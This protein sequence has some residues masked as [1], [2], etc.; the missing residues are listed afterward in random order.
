MPALRDMTPGQ[1]L[2]DAS[3]AEFIKQL[4]LGIAEAQT[5]LD[6]NSVA[7]MEAFTRPEEGL[8]GRSLLELGLLPA[9]Y[10]YQHADISVSLQIRLEVTETDEFGFGVDARVGRNGERSAS[11]QESER[12]EESGSRTEERSAQLAYR[13]NSEG[14]MVVNGTRVTPTGSDP[15]SRIRNLRERLVARDDIDAVFADPPER[16]LDISTDAPADRVAV[17]DRSVAFLKTPKYRGLLAIRQNEATEFVLNAD[18]TVETTA[19][20]SLTEYA[21]HVNQAIDGQE[22]FDTIFHPLNPERGY[23]ERIPFGHNEDFVTDEDARSFIKL[24]ARVLIATGERVSVEGMTDRTGSP[25]YNLDLGARRGRTVRRMFL[26][27]GVPES[28]IQLIDSR[29]EGRAT[30]AGEQPG[31]QNGN[32][33]AVWIDF[34]DRDAYWI[35][36]SGILEPQTVLANVAPDIRGNPGEGNGFVFLWT[37]APLDLSSHQVTID[38]QEFGLSGSAGGGQVA[39]SAEAHAHNLTTA[40]NA[41]EE[42]R[43]SRIGHV[44]QVMRATDEYTIQLYSR[45]DREISLTGREGIRV[46]EEFSRVRTSQVESQEGR[47]TTVSVGAS[48]NYRESR[49]FGLE[50]T[51][52]STISARLASVPAPDEFK[53]AIQILQAERRS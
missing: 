17:T 25:T 27:N 23:F 41:T 7:Q 48:L 46:T 30:E 9:F 24:T 51:G 8:G 52:N 39:G 21:E 36:V 14:A 10:H 19:Q 20:E 13:A 32:W 29:G 4:G 50:V 53:E 44:V 33:R 5:A 11:S 35:G 1:I 49:Q 34:P 2:A 37:P 38:G 16:S 22:G 45:S 47:R 18:T 42:L 28:Q 43:A 40:I 31:A 15:F 6:R 26:E 3:V 12:I